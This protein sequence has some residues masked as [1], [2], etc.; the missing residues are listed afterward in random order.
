[1]IHKLFRLEYYS[2]GAKGY[3]AK[4][5]G[6][7]FCTL[8][9][10]NNPISAQGKVWFE[11][12]G[13]EDGL[14]HSTVYSILQDDDGFIWIGT[15]NGLNCYDGYTFRSFDANFNDST[16][17]S[18]SWVNALFQDHDGF[19]WVGTE[20]G[21]LNRINKSNGRID[22]FTS[23]PGNQNSLASSYVYAISEDENSNLWIATNGGLSVLDHSRK[24]FRNYTNIP[25]DPNSLSSNDIYDLLIDS[26]KKIWIATYGGGLN[27]YNPSIDGFRRFIH[28]ADNSNTISCDTLWQMRQDRKD[29]NILWISTYYGLNRF[30]KSSGLFKLFMFGT[31]K[32]MTRP[33]NKIQ[34][35]INDDKGR[36]WVGTD[37]KGL[38][39]LDPETSEVRH[40]ENSP[41]DRTSLSDNSLL[42]LF[43]DR[44]GL[45]WVGTRNAGINLVNETGFRNLV[46]EVDGI[47]G[48]SV[49][50]IN[51][52]GKFFWL[53]TNKGM[54]RYDR[55]EGSVHQYQFAGKQ[56]TEK[57]KIVYSSLIDKDNDLWIGTRGAG[58][59]L[60]EENSFQFKSF[61]TDEK[62]SSTISGNSIYCIREDSKGTIWIGTY[63]NGLNSYNKKTGRFKRY[64][65]DSSVRNSLS[66]NEIMDI[67]PDKRNNLWIAIYGEGLNKLDLTTGHITT[68][69][70]VRDDTASINDNY[71]KCLFWYNDSTLCLGTYSGGL[72]IFNVGTGK[73][74]HYN[75]KNGLPSNMVMAICED[76]DH[77]LWLSTD[78][79]LCRFD[80]VTLRVRNFGLKNGF[81]DIE[82]NTGACYKDSTG[83]IFFGGTAGLTY[84]NPVNIKENSYKPDI[85]ILDFRLENTATVSGINTSGKWSFFRKD[86]IILNHKQ[87]S[88]T[89]GFSSMLFSSPE[90]NQY[91]YI[92]EGYDKK[93]NV[94]A[95][96]NMAHYSNIPPGKY[97]F[98]IR[99][100]NNDG[101]WSDSLSMI[102]I[103]IT[104]PFWKTI[105]FRVF[106]L[107]AVIFLLYLVILIREKTLKRNQELLAQK[108][109][110]NTLEIRKQSEEIL[111]QRDFAIRQK[112]VIEIQNAELEKHRTGLEQLVRER[113]AELEL[114]KKKAEESDKLKSGFIANMS[115]EIRTPMNA[116]IGFSNLLN[117]IEITDSERE[118]Y[119]KII[120]SSGN[121]LM[122]LIDDILDLSILEA[123]RIEL[124]MK[125]CNLNEIFSQLFNIFSE[126]ITGMPEKNLILTNDL[127]A[128][129]ELIIYTDPVRLSQILSNLLDNAIKFTETGSVRFGC[130]IHV[131]DGN[132]YL[133]F[134]VED[135]GEGLTN[136]QIERLFIRF[137]RIIDSN[138]K[139][140]RGT[141]LGLSIC[142]NL[143]EL[144]GGKIWVESEY[145]AG[146]VF[147]F[148]LPYTFSKIIQADEIV[149]SGAVNTIV[150]SLNPKV[151]LIVEDDENSMLLLKT[152]LSKY[153][154]AILQSYNGLDAIEIVKNNHVDLILM[155]INLPNMDGYQTSEIIKKINNKIVIIAQTAYAF[156]TEHERTTQSG[157]DALI[158]K[159]ITET[160]L[161]ELINQFV[162]IKI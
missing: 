2:H 60:L 98:K 11:K 26:D 8:F 69:R 68:Y 103:Q 38:Y 159:P 101:V 122:Q 142:K 145:N 146:S 100:S 117:N 37:E 35:L 125:N 16:S 114:A 92:L 9:I 1:M 25:S 162:N 154:F 137:S 132:K 130:D 43:Q 21:G 155:D 65:F 144:M 135:T 40:F 66:G 157:C 36:I 158:T 78:N 63:K 76:A 64:K 152:I 72:N 54:F 86:T 96:L 109:K 85:T 55:K 147:Y 80:P 23:V 77:N 75:R 129:K 39:C 79:G 10:V 106:I 151:I 116:I 17:I 127:S 81:S 139:L 22:K 84:F 134:Y 149:V 67:L 70:N 128:G 110:E 153:K 20:G 105:W 58:L 49:Y 7:L 41:A 27:L 156:K 29:K 108:V 131:P 91:K 148:T 32:S 107:A 97:I 52:Q 28:K 14:S 102:Y 87:S 90:K 120:K 6:I 138:K 19:I 59:Y 93:W 24:N 99:G 13:V 42:V 88:F 136:K 74:V 51:E 46:N 113:T 31:G 141:G 115:H 12:I 73:F 57:D 34:P 95:N 71:I 56:F 140:Y 112:A 33:D 61:Y 44:S 104:P 111:S 4:F 161:I 123:G 47:T 45:I 124:K 143:V 118:E 160:K 121:S 30:D 150:D 83:M 50:S 3:L 18:Y 62:D 15:K 119:I 126:K 48:H 53:G 5:A 82:F 94:T 89:I 133:R